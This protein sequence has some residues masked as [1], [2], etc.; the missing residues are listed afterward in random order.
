MNHFR[1]ISV[2]ILAV[3]LLGLLGG[4][5]AAL[6][7]ST[8]DPARKLGWAQE[9]MDNKN[10]PLPAEKLVNEAIEIY[11]VQ[12]NELGLAE[13]YR[14]YGLFFKSYAVAS[15]QRHYEE[16]G[17]LDKSATYA[18]RFEK[19][20]EYF[21]KSRDLLQK[22]GDLDSLPNVYVQIGITYTFMNNS[23]AAC[24]SYDASLK[25]HQSRMEQDPKLKYELPK[26]FS[27][28]SDAVV[29]LKKKSGCQL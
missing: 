16:S 24:N 2:A 4:C 21:E 23:I 6:V 18:K 11:T 19:S 1:K 28:F 22:N 3:Y 26:E 9:L 7:P 8:S 20:L 27:D 14:V 10:R 13:A 29:H 5:A 12:Q 15:Q 17:F 25:A